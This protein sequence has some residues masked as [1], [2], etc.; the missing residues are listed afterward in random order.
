MRGSSAPVCAAIVL[1]AG[2]ASAPETPPATAPAVAA[3]APAPPMADTLPAFERQQRDAAQ[4][5]ARQGRWADAVW[6]WDVVLA[7]RPGDAAAREARGAALA[8]A[9]SAA[10]DREARAHQ[11][12]QRGDLDGAIKLYLEALAVAPDDTSAADALRDI[13]RA[14]TRRG[15]L[16]GPR[17]AQSRPPASTGRNELEHASMLASQG[18]YESAIALLAP[19]ARSDARARA[20]LADIY[21]RQAQRLEANDRAGAIAALRHCL[22]LEP[23]HKAAAQKLKALGTPSG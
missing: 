7:L 14:R 18:E 13:E 8:S 10:A 9:K 23:G 16:V 17:S 3:Q 6:A 5:A 21:W 12:R 1:L 20:Q 15:N 4:A 11:A 19:L 2:C 22:L